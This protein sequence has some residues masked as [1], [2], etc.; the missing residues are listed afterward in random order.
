VSTL[1]VVDVE[2]TVTILPDT[3]GKKIY[4]VGRSTRAILEI[5][6]QTVSSAIFIKAPAHTRGR[7]DQNRQSFLLGGIG[8]VLTWPQH[9]G[10]GYGTQLVED[11]L[12]Y[13]SREWG[14]QGGVLFC[15]NNNL[16][17]YV[18]R[19]WKRVAGFVVVNQ[20]DSQ[21]PVPK[22]V[23]TMVYGVDNDVDLVLESLPW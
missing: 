16:A 2:P 18:K 14:I 5:G 23:N 1:R 19:G 9:R 8:A 12:E 3:W 13:M 6:E 17:W 10:K 22:K 7:T 4:G 11:S 15:T 21:M 20:P